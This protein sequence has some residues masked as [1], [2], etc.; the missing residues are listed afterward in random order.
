[1]SEFER[2]QFVWILEECDGKPQCALDTSHI[3]H[4]SI[5][6]YCQDFVDKCENDNFTNAV[7]KHN[8][9]NDLEV[10]YRCDVRENFTAFLKSLV[11]DCEAGRL[12]TRGNLTLQCQKGG[13]W[14][15]EPPVC[16]VTCQDP[17]HENSTTLC[18][19]SPFPIFFEGYNVTYTCRKN[20]RHSGGDL[21]R[22]CNG[23]GKWTGKKPVCK[24]CKC[25]CDRVRSQNF[26]KDPVVLQN[27]I[28]KL[29]K[30]LKVKM[31]KLSSTLRRKTCAKD[32]RQSSTFVG[33]VLGGVII[34]FVVVIIVLSDIPLLLRQIRYGP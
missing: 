32:E 22:I 30:E 7:L 8:T 17:F 24:R 19:T 23:S 5:S 9:V 25:P 10:Q 6:F 26:I 27:R 4:K 28:D 1:M 34:T 18:E 29:K 21:I 14:F 2:S 15:G 13:Q 20:H 3:Q 11:Y 33:S 12:L 16:N 31:E